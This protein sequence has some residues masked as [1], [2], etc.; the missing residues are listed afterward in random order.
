MMWAIWPL[1]TRLDGLCARRRSLRPGIVRVWC[2]CWRRSGCC[3]DAASRV[4]SIWGQQTN[5]MKH[6]NR[7]F[8][9]MH[10][11]SVAM[12]SLQVNPA[13]SDSPWFQP[14]AGIDFSSNRAFPASIRSV[15]LFFLFCNYSTIIEDNSHLF[16]LTISQHNN[17]VANMS[18][19][20]SNAHHIE[21]PIL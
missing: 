13:T 9:L 3:S 6:Q 1:H 5:W 19:M 14:L 8:R 18:T 4:C 17:K 12:I 15:F 16:W 11:S 10:G 2:R 21:T 7:G 20:R